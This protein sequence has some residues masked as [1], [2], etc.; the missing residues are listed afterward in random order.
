MKK[1]FTLFTFTLFF[2]LSAQAQS[3]SNL[4]TDIA[5]FLKNNPLP[6]SPIKALQVELRSPFQ[7]DSVL[8][9][10]HNQFQDSTLEN[11]QLFTYDIKGRTTGYTALNVLGNEIKSEY[12]YDDNDN[13]LTDYIY[14]WNN[15]IWR[16]V[17]RRTNTYDAED[18]LTLTIYEDIP[19]GQNMIQNKNKTSFTFNADGNI[20]S[21]IFESWDENLNNWVN[22]NRSYYSYDSEGKRTNQTTENWNSV[23]SE[24]RLFSKLDLE[25]DALG[26]LIY[27]LRQTYNFSNSIW[28]NTIQEFYT[29]DTF[30]NLIRLTSDYWSSGAWE[31]VQKIDRYFDVFNNLTLDRTFVLNPLFNNQVLLE[32]SKAYFYSELETST[33][34]LAEVSPLSCQFQ[35]PL[36]SNNAI[37]CEDGGLDATYQI[38]IFD[39]S[40]KIVLAKF[41]EGNTNFNLPSS[42]ETGMYFINVW[43]A[44]EIVFREKIVV[45]D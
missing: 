1:L 2:T 22:D 13:L 37:I 18:N 12:T 45:T 17:S 32:G 20:I 34:E 35:N 5:D 15:S 23:V 19:F 41:F 7:L 16:I 33:N 4:P 25:Y 42:L 40:G 26:Q 30:G 28:T 44:G 11:V 24:F 3:F 43:S 14:E 8:F 27:E 9:Y 36:S 29:Y 10:S 31:P 38:S 6:E 21:S 39:I